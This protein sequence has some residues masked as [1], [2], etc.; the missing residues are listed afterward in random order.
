MSLQLTLKEDFEARAVSPLMELGAYEALW[1]ADGSVSFKSLSQKFAAQPGAVP[2][3]FVERVRAREYAE[4]VRAR[5]HAA[6]INHFGVRVYGAGDYP[7]KL[8]D[9]ANPVELLYFQ[10][11]WDLVESRSV[12]VVGTRKPTQGGG[13]LR[14]RGGS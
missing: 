9:A 2:S 5:F 11:W 3:D 4:F 13:G 12:A 1:D 10:G 8:R 14:G 7:Q 6:N